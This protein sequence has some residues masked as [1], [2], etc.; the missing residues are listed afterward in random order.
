MPWFGVRS[1]LLAGVDGANSQ[2]E[3]RITVWQAR[4]AD[5]AIARAEQETVAYAA[6]IDG[7]YLGLAQACRMDG[8]PADGSEVFSL[9]RTS[10]L[11]PAAYLSAFFDT[12]D[13][14]QQLA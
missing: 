3:E 1:V 7:T 8:D 11:G 5:E 2:Y 14:H 6:D 13:E 10:S 4:D 12:G 9:I